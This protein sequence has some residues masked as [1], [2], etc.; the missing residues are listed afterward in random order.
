[1]FLG[2]VAS[3]NIVKKI[4][5]TTNIIRNIMLEGGYF[6][7]YVNFPKSTKSLNSGASNVKRCKYKEGTSFQPYA[8]LA[9]VYF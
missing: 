2:Y 1:M 3:F 7:D 6:A 9:F 5:L 4:V 8:C